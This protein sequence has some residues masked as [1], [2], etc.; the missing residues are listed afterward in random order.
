MIVCPGH[1]G[2]GA[3]LACVRLFGGRKRLD[4]RQRMVGRRNGLVNG[5][6]VLLVGIVAR[7]RTGVLVPHETADDE[8]ERRR[9]LRAV[10]RCAHV[11]D[12]VATRI[13]QRHVRPIG[14]GRDEQGAHLV[15]VVDRRAVVRLLVE[16]TVATGDEPS[17]TQNRSEFENPFH[18]WFFFYS[19]LI[20][21]FE[22]RTRDRARIRPEAE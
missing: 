15:Q 13:E 3:L 14:I 6:P 5:R 21:P 22:I 17:Q 9:R 18:I 20:I 19:I 12:I 16:E 1:Q 2:F 7:F 8:I 4:S 10:E 11:D